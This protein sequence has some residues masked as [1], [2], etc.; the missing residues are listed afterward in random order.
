MSER[1][2][3]R[4]LELLRRHAESRGVEQGTVEDFGD[5]FSAV[6][7]RIG[8]DSTLVAVVVPTPSEWLWGQLTPRQREVARLEHQR[9][10]NFE[11]ADELRVAV[12]TVRAHLR[13]IRRRLQ[14]GQ[15]R[16]PGGTPVAFGGGLVRAERILLREL[17]LSPIVGALAQHVGM[18]ARACRRHLDSIVRKLCALDPANGEPTSAD[19]RAA[20][21][22]EV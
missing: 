6:V 1:T 4:A 5:G 17:A 13:E 2:I 22:E 20:L 12:S 19:A 7:L 21:M 18:S 16:R 8:P 11:I 10:T 15:R 9:L 3:S 14:Q